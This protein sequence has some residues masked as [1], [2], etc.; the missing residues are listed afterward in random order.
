MPPACCVCGSDMVLGIRISIANFGIFY[1]AWSGKWLTLNKNTNNPITEQ[2]N[3]PTTHQ[4]NN[5]TIAPTCFVSSPIQC[6]AFAPAFGC[7]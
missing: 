7:S 1:N 4:P 6:T 2:P 3:S 5:L